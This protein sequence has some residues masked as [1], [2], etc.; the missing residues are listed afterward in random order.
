MLILLVLLWVRKRYWINCGGWPKTSHH[1]KKEGNLVRCFPSFVTRR[2]RSIT[3]K[4]D[5]HIFAY[6]LTGRRHNMLSSRSLFACF[7]LAILVGV[8]AQFYG[9]SALVSIIYIRKFIC[10]IICIFETGINNFWIWIQLEPE[11][12]M[13]QRNGLWAKSDTPF[14]GTGEALI[15]PN[16]KSILRRFF[17]FFLI[18]EKCWRH[19]S[20][21]NITAVII[22]LPNIRKMNFQVS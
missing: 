14:G 2:Q 22:N 9:Y 1:R 21:V 18:C 20:I 7:T 19:V 3:P 4:I 17:Q 13:Y 10:V 15:A 6:F 5:T 16:C 11:S 8:N 12:L